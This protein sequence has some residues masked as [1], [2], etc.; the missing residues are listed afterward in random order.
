MVL[1]RQFII[2]AEGRRIG[3]ILPSKNMISFPR[4]WSNGW[5]PNSA[6]SNCTKWRL[7]PPIRSFLADLRDTMDAWSG[8]AVL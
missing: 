3:V 7:L 6:T 5:L 4:H 8:W 2:D 1:K